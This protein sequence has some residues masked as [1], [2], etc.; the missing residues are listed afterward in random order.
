MVA[1]PSATR[2]LPPRARVVS[3][4]RV[5][6]PLP[7]LVA[8][9]AAS[10]GDDA[11][12]FENEVRPL[13]HEQ[14]V[15]CH[16]PDRQ[17]SGLRLDTIDG[18]VRGGER[19]ALWVAGKPDESLIVA[20][21]S[22]ER[23]ELQMPP[24]SKLDDAR[25]EKVAE[26]IRRGAA[27]PAGHGD[28]AA[29]PT[30][31]DLASRKR[32]WAWQ[33]VVRAEAPPVSDTAW[34]RDDVDRF[35]LAKLEESGLAPAPD[36]ARA[37]WLRRIALDLVGLPPTVA[38]QDAFLADARPDARERVVDRLLASPHFGEQ[39]ARHG[40]DLAR[41]A[42]GRGHEFDYTF[43]NAWAYR[44]WL[45]RAWNGDVPYDQLLRETV[46]GDLLETPRL[47]RATG[48]DE[49]LP[50]TGFWLLGE[51]VHSPVEIRGDEC[52]RVANQI[53]T[54]SKAFLGVTLACARCH[55]HKFDAITQRDYYSLSSFL[56]GASARQAPYEA[57]PTNRRVAQ[58]VAELRRER[59]GELAAALAD[60]AAPAPAALAWT[61]PSPERATT[62]VD[63]DAPRPGDWN[64]DGVAFGTAP[65]RAGELR[66]DGDPRAP[67]QA[68][69]ARGVLARDAALDRVRPAADREV[70]PTRVKLLEPGRVARTRSFA[71]RHGRLHWIVRGKGVLFACV[72]SHR[73]IE[74]PLHGATLV[75]FDTRGAWSVVT[76][77]LGDYVG[78]RV[79]GE[80]GLAPFEGEG[81]ARRAPDL[82]VA[83]L[84]DAAEA[85][86][87]ATEPEETAQARATAWRIARDRLARD[88]RVAAF[89]RE[90]AAL[91]AAMRD[92]SRV[93]PA[94]LEGSA[95]DE[96]LLVRGSWRT[97]GEPAPRRFLEALDG[98]A[99]LAA[100]EPGSGRLALAARLTDPANPLVARVAVNRIW[101]HL[102]G[103]GLV[104]TV[105]DFGALGER[106][107]HPELLDRL[108]ADFVADGWSQK[109]LIRRL[110][111]SRSYAMASVGGDA[112]ATEL[113]P[114]NALLH[115]MPVRR[116]TAEQLR[117]SLLL[118]SGSLDPTI[119]GPPVPTHLTPFMEGRGRPGDGPLD[120][121]GR[122]T[123]YLAVRRNFLDPF[124]LAFDFPNPAATCGRRTVSNVPAQSLALMNGELVQELARRGAQR[125]LAGPPVP[126]AERVEALLR[127]VFGRPA[128]AD[129]IA[130]SL[131][132]LTAQVADTSRARIRGG[133]GTWEDL[134]LWSD[135]VH[136]LFGSKAFLFVE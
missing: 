21:L 102:F 63:F 101:H 45:V 91:L 121:N 34:P 67:L 58:Q 95:F 132:W 6:T 83:A 12:W 4:R 74:G 96:A 77:E 7:L 29:A 14:C 124:L 48:A 38:E 61:Q 136:V 59:R 1:P 19:G 122:R 2:G 79:H 56:A 82:E 106:P 54:F 123:L 9:L 27:L 109:R 133:T 73:T 125:S 88:E 75:E 16:G 55:D 87:L 131:A 78:M 112:R 60:A 53:D 40:L 26:W 117:D 128:T 100:D 92:G 5:P 103:R 113:D 135:F 72:A 69:A 64:Q 98:D 94:L 129:E 118:A 15:K 11:A 51:A 68:I 119:G 115:A 85:P 13:F 127:A 116:L 65:L 97:E 70:D 111:L 126:P 43:P 30:T 108:A 47:D 39:W 36:A 110:V 41:Y 76:Q 66:F 50:A 24:K 10:A 81:D 57:L 52:D 23:E 42:E 99:P 28:G 18:L 80:I 105:D 35:V 93:A 37:T 32:H 31:F 33:P 107:S 25:R 22:W 134:T 89:G 17:R 84:I 3:M 62:I 44:D 86:Q 20:A 8:L 49:S 90:Q 46:A 114:T 71:L 120:G 104:A 130:A